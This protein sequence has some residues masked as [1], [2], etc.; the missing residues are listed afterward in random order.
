MSDW[1]QICETPLQGLCLLKCRRHADSRGHFSRL[2]CHSELDSI[3]EGD[4][5]E[6]ANYSITK[7]AGTVRG[8]HFQRGANAEKKLVRCVQGEIWDV[9]VDLRD[10]SPTYLQWYAATLSAENGK[11]LLIPE[12]FAHGFQTQTPDCILTYFHT[13]KYAPHAEGGIHCDDPEIGI[14]WPIDSRNLSNRDDSLPIIKD[15][16]LGA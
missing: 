10:D 13:K 6:Q 4:G 2:Y 12:G 3:L 9:A 8:L 7:L 16:Q 11:G 1:F 14:P 15:R 5:V